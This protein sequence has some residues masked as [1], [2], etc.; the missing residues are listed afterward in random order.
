MKRID[1]IDY[2]GK[3]IL[4][5]DF[6]NLLPENLPSYLEEAKTVI[7][8]QPEHSVLI[9]TNVTNLRFDYNL[10]Q[11]IMDYTK[12]NKPYIKASAIIGLSGLQSIIL[13][14]IKLSTGRD[15]ALFDNIDEAKEWL[16]QH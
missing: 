15:F 1:F 7:S 2:K 16:V 9:M 5:M 13:N 12:H 3:Q 8:S 6:S 14:S 11:A 10:S 4:Y